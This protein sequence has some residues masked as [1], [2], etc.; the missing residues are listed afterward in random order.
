MALA[1]AST[2]PS[3]PDP[4][5]LRRRLGLQGV[6]FGLLL[7][8]VFAASLY[9]GIAADRRQN[10]RLEAGRRAASAARRLPLSSHERAEVGN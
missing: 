6:A 4:L 9:G 7:L 10:L 5:R 2:P 8:T 3:L 1:T